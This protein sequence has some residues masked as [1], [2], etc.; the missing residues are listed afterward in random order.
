MTPD[1][2]KE[3]RVNMGKSQAT[4]AF[5]LGVTTATYVQWETGRRAPPAAARRLFSVLQMLQ[6]QCPAIHEALTVP[7]VKGKPGPRGAL[8]EWMRQT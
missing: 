2:L 4:F 5:Y 8:P 7:P 6:D 3:W 1:Q